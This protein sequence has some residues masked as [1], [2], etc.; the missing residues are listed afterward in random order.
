MVWKVSSSPDYIKT[1]RVDNSRFPLPTADRRWSSTAD[2][3][4]VVLEPS[5]EEL[6]SLVARG[7]PAAL[8]ALYDRHAS[9]LLGFISVIVRDRATG[10]D[11]LQEVFLRVWSRASSFVPGRGSFTAWLFGI[12]RNLCISHLRQ[13][14]ARPQI[15]EDIG[16][17]MDQDD[18]LLDFIS[19]PAPSVLETVW[20]EERSQLVRAAL[21]TLP[22]EQRLVIELSYFQGLTR[23]EIAARL[24]WAEGTVHTRARLG[25]Q[26]LAMYLAAQGLGPDDIS[27]GASPAFVNQGWW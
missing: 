27:G 10:E 4:P 24:G 13:Q 26:K 20:V 21:E 16:L 19:D 5:D 7:E 15:C 18:D 3:P 11:L 6:M 12:A 9:A 1:V 22:D 17:G 23:R 25:L 14:R 8:E 2:R